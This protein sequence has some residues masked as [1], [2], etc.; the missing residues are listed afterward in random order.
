LS[1]V[2]AAERAGPPLEGRAASSGSGIAGVEADGRIADADD[3]RA[4]GIVGVWSAAAGLASA[5]LRRWAGGRLKPSSLSSSCCALLRLRA[6][7][8]INV[9][10]RG[11]GEVEA[12][13]AAGA[14]VV[15][16]LSTPRAWSGELPNAVLGFSAQLH[17]GRGGRAAARGCAR[18]AG[19][20]F[21]VRQAVKAGSS[22]LR[23]AHVNNFWGVK[24]TGQE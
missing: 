18:M 9:L 13:A 2:T 20:V 1:P 19:G 3:G 4:G 23:A 12:G 22:M 7:V 24:W 8:A 6:S 17:F 10:M 15:S 16:G 11:P 14:A 5:S 21:C